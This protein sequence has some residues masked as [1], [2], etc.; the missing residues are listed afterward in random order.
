MDFEKYTEK[1]KSFL[2]QAQTLAMRSGHQSLE[3]EHLLKVMLDD[4]TGVISKVIRAADGKVDKVK[5]EVEKA[6]ARL[7]VVEGPGAG[8]LRLSSD[9]VK[10]MDNALQIAQ[11]AGDQFVTAERV[12]QAMVLA[13]KTD[14][15]GTLDTAG[16]NDQSINQAI[17]DMRKGRTADSP[18]AEDQFDALNKYAHDLTE[19]AANAKL[20]PI[21]GRDEEIRRTIQVL[22]RRT[23]NNPVLIGEPGVGKTAIVEGLAQRIVNGDVPESLKNK[24][25]M[26]LDLGALLA[27][28][29]FRGEFEERLKAVLDE[30]RAS[31][32]GRCR[33]GRRRHGCRQY[34]QTGAGP[35]GVAYGWRNDSE[36]IP[37]KHRKR[38]RSRPPVPAGF[39]R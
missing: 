15:A 26:S 21:I 25:L 10:I 5:S 20:D 4:E 17:N 1:T 36:R 34:A 19:A 3:P 16:L 7:P 22:S 11:K 14:I 32:A 18:N 27:G 28:A 23:K 35:R 31:H 8:Q 6:L 30:I 38:C 9:L 33:Q 13:K 29:K 37:Q 39:R 12:L 2:Q 24:R